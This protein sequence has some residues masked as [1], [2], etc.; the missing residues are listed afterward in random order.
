AVVGAVDLPHAALADRHRFQFVPV[1]DDRPLRHHAT[2]PWGHTWGKGTPCRR[3]G[4]FRDT[5]GPERKRTPPR[6]PVRGAARR[7][8]G[9][10]FTARGV[11]DGT[12]GVAGRRPTTD[13]SRSRHGQHT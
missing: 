3:T 12:A 2:F 7:A 5:G 4:R 11:A 1:V 13:P 6:T 10:G 9:R 8:V